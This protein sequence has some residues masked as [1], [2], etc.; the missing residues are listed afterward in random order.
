VKILHRY[1]LREHLG[2]LLFALTALT[3]ILLLQ[4]VG[5][6]IGQLVGKGLSPWVVVEFFAL[7]IPLTIALTLPMAVLRELGSIVSVDPPLLASAFRLAVWKL[8]SPVPAKPH[9]PSVSTL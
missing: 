7:S 1:V 4:Y 6:N 8:R 2:P 9:E 3:S 5:K